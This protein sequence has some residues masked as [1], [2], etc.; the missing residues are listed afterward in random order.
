ME[1][2]TNKTEL[3]QFLGMINYLAKFVENLSECTGPVEK[4]VGKESQ[5]HWSHDQD[6][7]FNELK[8]LV[9]EAPVLH[10]YDV[11]KPVI[12][13]VDNSSRGVGAVVLQDNHPIAFASKAFTESQQRYA[14]IEKEL[15]AIV[16]GCQKFHQYVFGR[17]FDVETD[18]KPLE[19]ILKKPLAQAPPRLQRMLLKLQKYAMNM[20]YKKGSE[21]FVA[22]ALSRNFQ[23]HSENDIDDSIEISVCMVDMLPMSEERVKE[24]QDKTK[25]DPL[26]QTLKNVILQGWPECRYNLDRELLPYWNFRS[27]LF[28]EDDLIFKSHKPV[29]PRCLRK[30]MVNKAH[31]GHQGIG[32]SKDLQEIQCF[33][34]EWLVILQML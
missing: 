25:A 17:D 23:D 16:F 20:K 34:Q 31:E 3:K 19:P 5:W 30:L 15:T 26:M 4:I 9:T 29:V 22:D 21:L 33:G 7:S 27:E 1:K 14:Q 18:H 10:Y 6:K 11:N 13:S 2:P 32:K 8:R 12:I 28:V 24:F